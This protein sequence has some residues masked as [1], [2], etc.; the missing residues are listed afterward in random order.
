LVAWLSNLTEEIVNYTIYFFYFTLPFFFQKLK[1]LWRNPDIGTSCINDACVLFV[2]CLLF[3]FFFSIFDT[4]SFKSP[5]F[6][7][8]CPVWSVSHSLHILKSIDAPNYLIWVNSSENSKWLVLLVRS[9]NTETHNCSV[10][11]T[12]IF[13]RPYIVKIFSFRIRVN[14]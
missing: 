11:E 8:L 9:C 10:N 7:R 12:S 13:Q 2:F 4:V 5:L 1:Y 3:T 6:Y 14:C